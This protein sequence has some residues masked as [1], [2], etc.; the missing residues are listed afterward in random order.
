[1]KLKK[2]LKPVGV[3]IFAMLYIWMCSVVF[4]PTVEKENTF[5]ADLAVLTDKIKKVDEIDERISKAE[6]ENVT[7]E[8]LQ[9]KENQGNSK[10][11]F[12]P[13]DPLSVGEFEVGDIHYFSDNMLMLYRG[14]RLVFDDVYTDDELSRAREIINE[15]ILRKMIRDSRDIDELNKQSAKLI[16]LQLNEAR[17]R[18][19]A[20]LDSLKES[21]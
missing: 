20:F 19:K 10:P 4:G 12:T 1:M 13:V 6:M 18:Q 5:V 15:L 3:L 2:F 21:K 11:D 16:E 7:C 17:A 8:S 14:S 9:P